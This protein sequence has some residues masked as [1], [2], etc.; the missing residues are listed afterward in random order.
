MTR[1]LP[2]AVTE[3]DHRSCGWLDVSL[4]W[5]RV[6]NALFVQVIDWSADDDFAIE[7]SPANAAQAFRHPYAYAALQG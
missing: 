3:L 1:T 6:T 4:F 7:V 5:N 2:E